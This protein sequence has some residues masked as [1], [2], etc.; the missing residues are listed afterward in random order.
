MR[1]ERTDYD[2]DAE[3][4]EGGGRGGRSPWGCH[5]P[6]SEAFARAGTNMAMGSAG[7]KRR[8]TAASAEPHLTEAEAI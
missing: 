8:G 4:R 2:R 5:V 6:R 7:T 3:A 1:A